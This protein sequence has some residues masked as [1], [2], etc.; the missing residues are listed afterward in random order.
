VSESR[1]EPSTA[2]GSNHERFPGEATRRIVL[3]LIAAKIATLLFVASV[4]LVYPA[5]FSEEGYIGVYFG[6]HGEFPKQLPSADIVFRTWDAPHY[7]ALA[8]HGYGGAGPKNAFYPLYPALVRLAAPAFG[9][10]LLS[11][12]LTLSTA[13]GLLAL[14]VLHDLLVR[15]TSIRV[16]NLTVLLLCVQPAAFFSVLPYSESLFLLLLAVFCTL[17]ARERFWWAGVI[18]ALLA[19]TRAVGVFSAL[20]LMAALYGSRRSIATWACC[21][22]PI[23]G[24]AG[25]FAILYG[26]TGD[27]WL[28]FAVQKNFTTAPAIA[29]LFDPVTFARE[30]FQVRRWHS[31]SGSLL[32]RLSFAAYLAGLGAL[33]IRARR[34]PA[35]RPW[36]VLSAALGL[37]P[38]ILTVLMSFTRYLSVIFP[39]FVVSAELLAP[40]SRRIALVAVTLTLLVLQVVLLYRHVTFRWA[41]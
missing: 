3:P 11:S 4:A 30:L 7:L 5:G 22:L 31:F 15:T 8:A 14:F 20:P 9:G 39:L 29:R 19:L 13:F 35:A 36:F 18:G 25:Y 33:F 2:V 32:E 21:V 38:A 24:W 40:K 27:P 41:G 16:A 23:A 12:A 28:G 17:L 1:L 6:N 34:Q 26:Q 10:D 37:V